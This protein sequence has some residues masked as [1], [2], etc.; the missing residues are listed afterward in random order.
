MQKNLLDKVGQVSGTVEE[1]HEYARVVSASSTELQISR[2]LSSGIE[3]VSNSVLGS[4]LESL[5]SASQETAELLE[6]KRLASEK[7]S[8]DGQQVCMALVT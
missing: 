2:L 8:L 7:L 5:R 3:T 4:A 1:L 6:E